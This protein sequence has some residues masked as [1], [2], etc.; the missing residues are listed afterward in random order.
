MLE[1]AA[2]VC[3]YVNVLA[4]AALVCVYMSVLAIAALVCVPECAGY[5]SFYVYM[6]C[7]S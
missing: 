6:K 2:L 3:V 7:L 5:T 4:T 1:I